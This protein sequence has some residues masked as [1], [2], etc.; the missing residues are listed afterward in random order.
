VAH[1][2]ILITG[3]VGCGKS[4]LARELAEWLGGTIAEMDDHELMG[5][6][7]F[8]AEPNVVIVEECRNLDAIK[9]I[10][11]SDMIRCERKGE[12]PK[13]IPVPHIICTMLEPPDEIGRRF[14]HI[15]LTGGTR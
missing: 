3:P 5:H 11:T 2:A 10:V 6:F 13:E 14:I 9:R 4:R 12:N 8:A 7:A 1:K 15:P